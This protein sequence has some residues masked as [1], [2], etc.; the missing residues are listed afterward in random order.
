VAEVVKG[1]VDIEINTGSAAAELKIL[2]QQINSVFLSLNKNNAASLA[3]SQKYSTSLADMVNSSKVFTAETVRMRTAAG[4]LD[5]TLKKGQATL[6][7]YFSAKYVRN[8]ALFAETLDLARQKASVLQTQFVAT[9]KSSKG[10]QDAL[11]IRP[12]QAFADQATIASQ[13]TQILSS[14]F[15]Q[16]TTQLINFGKNVQWAGRQL[17]VGFTVPL[18]IFGTTAGKVF[19]DLEKQTVAFKKVYGDLFTTPKELQQNL[20]AVQDLARE[21]TKYGIAVK[22]TISLAAQAAAAGRQNSDLTDAVAQSTRLATLGQMDQNAA[23]ETTIA[24]Q[25]AFKLSGDELANTINFLNMVENQTVVSLQDIAAAIPRV[26]PVIEGL[27]GSVKDLTVFLAAMQEGGVSA[28]QGANAL[29]SGLASLINPS[30]SA[31]ATLGKFGVNLDAIIQANKGDLMKTVTGFAEALSTLGEFE[32]QQALEEVFGKFQYARLGALFENIIREGSQAKQV[33]DTLG[34]SVE[35]LAMTADK[36]L[37]TIEEAFSVQLRGAIERF[38]LAIAPI[39]EIFVKLAIPLVNF[40]TSIADAFNSLPD[41]SKKFIAFATII[42]G[43]VIPAGTM[44]FGLLMNLTGTLAKLFQFMGAF[45][46]EF[47]QGGIVGAFKNATQSTKYFSTAEIEAALAAQQLGTATEFTNSALRKQ[48]T[49]AMGAAGAVKY[50]GD[51]YTILIAKMMEAA[52]LAPYT[53]GVGQSA[54]G[55]A[56]TGMSATGR[57]IRPP[58]MRN[59]GGRIFMSD[60]STVPGTGNSDTVPAMLTPGEFVVNKNATRQNLGLLYAINGGGAGYNK[61]GVTYAS[62]GA[63]LG[64]R[65]ALE[66]SAA[67]LGVFT[68]NRRASATKATVAGAASK[69][70]I[71]GLLNNLVYLVNPTTNK[72]LIGNRIMGGFDKRG[73]PL[74]QLKREMT[75]DIGMWMID[76]YAGQKWAKTAYK[77]TLSN[78]FDSIAAKYPGKEIRFLDSKGFE[79]IQDVMDRPEYGNVKFVSVKE[80]HNEALY[81]RLRPDH[82]QRL[83][84]DDTANVMKQRMRSSTGQMGLRSGYEDLNSN[85]YTKMQ[86]SWR[87]TK[88]PAGFEGAHMYGMGGKIDIQNLNKGGLKYLVKS[89]QVRSAPNSQMIN[90]IKSDPR[91]KNLINKFLDKEFDQIFEGMLLNDAIVLRQKGF[92]DE[93]IAKH[94][95]RYDPNNP[96]QYREALSQYLIKKGKLKGSLSKRVNAASPAFREETLNMLINSGL[97]SKTSKNLVNY[98]RGHHEP[99]TKHRSQSTVREGYMGQAAFDET[100]QLYRILKTKGI[101]LGETASTA[102]ELELQH[103]QLRKRLNLRDFEYLNKG[104]MIPGMQYANKGKQIQEAIGKVFGIN[105]NIPAVMSGALPML[106]TQFQNRPKPFK[107]MSEY[108]KDKS[109]IDNDVYF[110]YPRGGEPH[111]A[112]IFMGRDGQLRKQRIGYEP[113]SVSKLD[114]NFRHG[115]DPRKYKEEIIDSNFEAAIYNQDEYLNHGAKT[116]RPQKFNRGNI[117][118]GTGNTD[119]VPAMLTPGEFVVNKEATRNNMALLKAINNGSM[120][121]YNKGGKIPGVQYF[122]TEEQNRLVMDLATNNRGVAGPISSLEKTSRGFKI[123]PTAQMGMMSAGFMLPMIGQQM[124][125]STNQLSKT[126][127]DFIGVLT[128]AAMIMSILPSK[129]GAMIAGIALIGVAAYKVAQKFKEIQDSGNEFAKAMYGSAESTKKFSETFGKQTASQRLATRVAESGG[130][131]LSDQSKQAAQEFIKSDLGKQLVKDI[132]TVA[133]AKGDTTQALLNQLSRQVVSGTITSDEA[134]A[135]SAQVAEA[136]GNL[137]LGFNVSARIEKIFDQ[138]GKLITENVVKL[139]STISPKLDEESIKSQV[140]RLYKSKTYSGLGKL[141]GSI[142]NDTAQKNKI[143]MGLIQQTAIETANVERESRATVRLAF[144]DGKLAIEDYNRALDAINKNDATGVVFQ[145]SVDLLIK[146]KG[147]TEDII[148][149]TKRGAGTALNPFSVPRGDAPSVPGTSGF[150]PGK[151]DQQQVQDF[152]NEYTKSFIEFS[153]SVGIPKSVMDENLDFAEKFG[154]NLIE[155]SRILSDIMSGDL[156]AGTLESLKSLSDEQIF[157]LKA[158]FQSGQTNQEEFLDLLNQLESYPELQEKILKITVEDG[159]DAIVMTKEALEV[160]NTIDSLPGDIRASINLDTTDL[161]AVLGYKDEA[162]AIKETYD[163]V[164]DYIKRTKDDISKKAIQQKIIA[165][166]APEGTDA[167]FILN[168]ITSGGTKELDPLKLPIF[169][170]LMNDPKIQGL[171]DIV[172]GKNKNISLAGAV[173]A[174]KMLG[175]ITAGMNIPTLDGS[176]TTPGAGEKSQIQQM[177]DSAKESAAYANALKIIRKESVLTEEQLS[178]MSGEL[179]I[180]ISKLKDKKKTLQEY[181]TL[182]INQRKIDQE[183]LTDSEK[184]LQVLDVQEKV[185]SR[186]LT[187]ID[188]RINAKQKEINKEQDLNE[189]R[190]KALDSLSKEEQKINDVYDA[191]IKALDDVNSAN[192]R[193]SSRQRSRIDLATSLAGGDIAGAAAAA[194]EITSKEAQ[195]KLEDARTLLETQRQRQIDAL[196]TSINNKLMTRKEI[197]S[198][199][200][201]S[202]ERIYD[203]SQSIKSIET[204]KLSIYNLQEQSADR[205]FKLELQAL[206]ATT[207]N[208]QVYEEINRLAN[209]HN[210]IVAGRP[211]SD[212]SPITGGTSSPAAAAANQKSIQELILSKNVSYGG[213]KSEQAGI[214]KALGMKNFSTAK[215]VDIQK[216]FNQATPQQ[217]KTAYDKAVAAAKKKAFGGMMY[218]GSNEAPP[219]LKMAYGSMVPGM[220]NTD[221]VP[222]L[223]TPGEFVIRKSV[224]SAYMPLLEQLNGNIYPRAAMPKGSAKNNSNLYNNSYSINVNV[225]GTDAS[226]DEIANAVMSKIKQVES[227]SLRGVKVV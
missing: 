101:D 203:I 12:L 26:A 159:G 164:S 46:K 71:Q 51:S 150:V 98:D 76:A 27:G 188:R 204:E 161:N 7:Q 132:Q 41:F 166:F 112:R 205:R 47:L 68:S 100:N 178:S 214:A 154:S 215:A 11:A 181:K 185:Y 48:V 79:R 162:N 207:Q 56:K 200:E 35:E 111:E 18:T 42:T 89:R 9:G 186:Q 67:E 131:T 82:L 160:L 64:P 189:V 121:G 172:S 49:Q 15:R 224:A 120:S 187:L 59:D 225:A 87:G 83:L 99:F 21:Y 45:G 96:G 177:R 148:N 25:S 14:M 62:R 16:G 138:D 125:Q 129:M 213:S 39:G 57:V 44:F 182:Y 52:R 103:S 30:K 152:Y 173:A 209:E 169:L 10:M 113:Y 208:K 171:I 176:S 128:P 134:K 149:S 24:L 80:L 115:D 88:R 22:D 126:I 196:T 107:K 158:R 43:L 70:G 218:R 212:F 13:R 163:K 135:I 127:G 143:A 105:S 1:I 198:A 199:I 180:E 167:S 211:T 72:Q 179:A 217:Q 19:A 23:L 28:E 84:S 197:E 201:S 32:Q 146:Q 183:L 141:I 90:S 110:I 137:K 194:A 145:K 193:N 123:G 73:V 122:A 191:R 174:S 95:R 222:A 116:Y 81:N 29:K 66:R 3:A 119:T 202:N 206:A 36:E 223:L 216:A 92:S 190:Q 155:S 91:I 50:L 147:L 165:K 33:I 2:Q 17:M 117:V 192:E 37:K 93:G 227:R 114:P 195:Y 157:E 97:I 136:T 226:P 106:K 133:N 184:Q 55:L 63:Y 75:S 5:D 77:T 221:R 85:S 69:E 102:R 94:L 40:A 118:P 153:K 139:A 156:T 130:G 61:G 142:D 219:A 151:K 124:Q 31:T 210:L 34:Y 220:G 20:K 104:G 170:S 54:A 78:N 74:D 60:G 175:E 144:L 53:M 140:D 6:G 4:A 65:E 108:V 38:K 58:Q 109:F 8:G 168:Y 86:Q